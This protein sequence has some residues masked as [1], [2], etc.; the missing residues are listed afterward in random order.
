[1]QQRTI[2]LRSTCSNFE[3]QKYSFMFLV[4]AMQQDHLGHT[5]QSELLHQVNYI[6]LAQKLV[7]EM[8]DCDRESCGV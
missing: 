6:G 1:M 7:T 2:K 4:C 3:Y 5:L 8:F